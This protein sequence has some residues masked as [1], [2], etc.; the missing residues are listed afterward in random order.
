M[1]DKTRIGALLIVALIAAVLLAL[2][3]MAAETTPVAAT[4][5]ES[6]TEMV[7]PGVNEAANA[8]VTMSTISADRT[9]SNGTLSFPQGGDTL[10]SGGEGGYLLWET[11]LI[12]NDYRISVGL[13]PEG[14]EV[15]SSNAEWVAIRETPSSDY[16]GIYYTWHPPSMSGKKYS[17]ILL[18][19][20]EVAGMERGTYNQE[21]FV[22]DSPFFLISSTPPLPPAPPV[23]VPT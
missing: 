9:L 17:L 5:N 18:V 8:S 20:Y 2:P 23:S 13:V 15:N 16:A 21:K 10:F 4:T 6:V 22:T 1:N 3:V 14:M 7:A 11:D 12:G 19:D